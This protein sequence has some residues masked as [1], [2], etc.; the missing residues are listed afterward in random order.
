M[1][2]ECYTFIES[3]FLP[4]LLGLILVKNPIGLNIDPK[5]IEIVCF[6]TRVF[7]SIGASSSIF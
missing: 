4:K 5:W 2:G 7:H 3:G 1:N 6:G